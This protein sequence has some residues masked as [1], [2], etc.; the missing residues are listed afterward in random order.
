MQKEKRGKLTSEKAEEI[1]RSCKGLPT[2]KYYN[3]IFAEIKQLSGISAK[4]QDSYNALISSFRNL[5]CFLS[6]EDRK[7]YKE[8]SIREAMLPLITG[9]GSTA[10]IEKIGNRNASTFARYSKVICMR[11]CGTTADKTKMQSYL[12]AVRKAVFGK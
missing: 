11:A 12:T 3:A 4:L 8:S 9:R 5:S 7:K 10:R 1:R 6:E 2:S